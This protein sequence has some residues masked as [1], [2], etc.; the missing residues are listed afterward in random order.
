MSDFLG[1]VGRIT[2]WVVISNLENR[3]INATAN[4]T[5]SWW[6][7]R[8]AKKA[9]SKNNSANAVPPTQ[10]PLPPQSQ[11]YYAAP[12]PQY[13][14][15]QASYAPPPPPLPPPSTGSAQLL[16][17]LD[18][19]DGLN[20]WGPLIVIMECNYQRYQTSLENSQ[21]QFLFPIHQFDNDILYIWVQTQ[22]QQ[23]LVAQGEIA[24]RILLNN[25]N[26]WAPPEQ[27]W[28]P[29]RDQNYGSVGQLVVTAQYGQNNSPPPLPQQNMPNSPA[30]YYYYS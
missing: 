14:P 1:R 19:L 13:Q 12:P 18:H 4:K 20:Q 10:S 17:T 25:Y 11:A 3:A 27:R 21:Q 24:V 28:I 6:K 29:L 22:Y 15:P 7:N 8:K 26:G 23:Q 30:P 5:E 2:E 9:A 16:I